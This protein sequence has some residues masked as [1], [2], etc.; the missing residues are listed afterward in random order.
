MLDLRRQGKIEL[1][2]EINISGNIAA[3]GYAAHSIKTIE[4]DV[5]QLLGKEM[6]FSQSDIRN[7]ATGNSG[8]KVWIAAAL[9]SLE[10][11]SRRE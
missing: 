11:K 1:A 5:S 10:H 9:E 7:P 6:V 4:I 3:T 8:V 2:D